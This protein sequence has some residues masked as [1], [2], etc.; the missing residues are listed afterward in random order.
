MMAIDGAHI[1]YFLHIIF[2]KKHLFV[3]MQPGNGPV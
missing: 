2:M 1:T 3:K